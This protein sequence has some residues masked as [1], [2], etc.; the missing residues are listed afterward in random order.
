MSM[1]VQKHHVTVAFIRAIYR[2]ITYANQYKNVGYHGKI[3][4]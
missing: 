2:P 1:T 3:C 4:V